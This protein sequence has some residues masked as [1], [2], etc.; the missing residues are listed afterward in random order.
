MHIIIPMSGKG[1]RFIEA[2]FTTPKPLVQIDQKP[3]IEHVC[4]LFPGE[5]KFTF[6]CNT[7]HLANTNLKKVLFKD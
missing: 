2:G 7:N 4:D 1:S 6:I 5:D 3:I